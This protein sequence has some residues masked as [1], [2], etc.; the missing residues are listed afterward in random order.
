MKMSSRLKIVHL[1]ALAGAVCAW[2]IP[3][4]A[5]E[6]REWH[7]SGYLKSYGLAQTAPD[8]SGLPASLDEPLFQSQN[9]VRLMLASQ[10]TD[11]IAFE[12]HYEA[13]PIFSSA[14]ALAGIGGLSGL[15]PSG[16]SRFRYDDLDPD[17]EIDGPENV[18]L[19]NL[20]R[21]NVQVSLGQGQLTLGRQAI[22]FGSAR[23]V[24]P[25][26]I[27]EPFVVSTL[28]RE[29]R[30]GIDAIRYEHNLGGFSELDF[31]LV[32]GDEGRTKNSAAFLRAKTSINGND[33]EVVV[34][35][36]EDMTLV[37]GGIER[38]LGNFGFWFEGAYVASSD[39]PD[40]GRISTGLDMAL[41]ETAFLM[42]EYHHSSAGS[43]DPDD[44]VPNAGSEPFTRGGVFLMGQNYIAPAIT[45]TATPLLG[46]SAS[47]F[48]NIDDGSIFLRAAGEYSL[49]ED[50]YMDFGFYL[51]GGE[52]GALTLLPTFLTL[53]S[54][55]GSFPSTIYA[56]LRY[57][58]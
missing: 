8:I 24:S 55:F 45:W 34:I 57:Y 4:Q 17:H 23:L 29:Y 43:R 50:L 2:A 58:F 33:I 39:G 36:Q 49:T 54:E 12:F 35:A 6:A 53:E 52:G 5:A 31:G 32:F 21:L 1:L 41:S 51:A 14:G 11:K 26:D 27:F 48:Y 38:A 42:V 28:D 18:L 47:G 13:K 15:T 44:Y 20:D 3:A 9:A 37:G 10:V 40:Y 30:L 56:S 19:Q 25:T 7:F 22:A 16:G 46:I